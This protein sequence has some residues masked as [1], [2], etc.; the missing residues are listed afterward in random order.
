[1]KGFTL[2]ELLVV[3]LII[4]ILSSVALP[5]YQKAV[6]KSRAMQAI[7]LLTA[8]NKA[9]QVYYMANGSYPQSIE[10][11][12]I[13]LPAWKRKADAGAETNYVYSWGYCSF[14][15]RGGNMACNIRYSFGSLILRLVPVDKRLICIHGGDQQEKREQFCKNLGFQKSGSFYV[16][17]L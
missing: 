6:D 13:D 14:D 9:E 12:D 3:V 7:T 5:Q 16:I 15:S 10:E 11:M 4:G 8:M 17:N 2:I 1:M